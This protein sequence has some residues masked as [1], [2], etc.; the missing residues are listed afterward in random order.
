MPRIFRGI[1]VLLISVFDNSVSY[2]H[3]RYYSKICCFFDSGGLSYF[4]NYRFISISYP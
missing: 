1:F 4:N 2:V 3:I